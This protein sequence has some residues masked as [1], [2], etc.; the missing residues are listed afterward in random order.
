MTMRK[1]I[2]H[3][4]GHVSCIEYEDP[5]QVIDEERK[6]AFKI[7]YTA[8]MKLRQEWILICLNGTRR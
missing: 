6:D 3:E 2:F 1:Y 4:D 8:A 7:G 5:E